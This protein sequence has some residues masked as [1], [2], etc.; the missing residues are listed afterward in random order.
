MALLQAIHFRKKV[1]Y[2]L[3]I[4][5]L[6][7]L[8]WLSDKIIHIITEIIFT[9]SSS[10]LEVIGK[11]DFFFFFFNL[12]GRLFYKRLMKSIY[13]CEA[14]MASFSSSNDI[15]NQVDSLFLLLYL[16]N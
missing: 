12:Q 10:F 15:C 13:F 6:H 3:V 2:Q 4:Y 7:H 16:Y 11:K 9:P 5:S 8:K 14:S 1:V